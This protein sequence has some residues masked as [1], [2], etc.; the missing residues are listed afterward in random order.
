MVRPRQKLHFYIEIEIRVIGSGGS[1]VARLK[2]KG[3]DGK[4]HQE[5]SLRFN[6][7]QHGKTYEVR[8]NN[9]LTD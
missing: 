2:L 6:L 9:G 7:T 8:I 1:M 4:I 3:I 5:W